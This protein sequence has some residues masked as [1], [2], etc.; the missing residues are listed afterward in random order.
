M[1]S[2][3]GKAGEQ[4]TKEINNY[5]QNRVMPVLGPLQLDL[6]IKQ[7]TSIKDY[8]IEWLKKYST[9]CLT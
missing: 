9:S 6:L 7:P 3:R 1:K 2:N 5:I 8:C 4:K